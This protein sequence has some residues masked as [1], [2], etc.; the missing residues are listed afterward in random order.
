MVVFIKSTASNFYR[1]FLIR[2]TWGKW[3]YVEGGLLKVLF[4]VG[5]PDTQRIADLLQE[6]SR[7]N[8]DVL[9]FNGPDNYRYSSSN[10]LTC[11]VKCPSLMAKNHVQRLGVLSTCR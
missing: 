1:R 7:R 8:G 9:N 4:V 3:N 2:R 11:W 6:E 10:R 5:K